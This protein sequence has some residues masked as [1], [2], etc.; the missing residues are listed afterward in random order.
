MSTTPT[1]RNCL[2]CAVPLT[3]AGSHCFC[4]LP[5]AALTTLQTIGSHQ[6]LAAGAVLLHEGFSATHVYVICAGTIKLSACS[7]DGKLLLLRIAGPGDV[8]GLSATLNGA[9]YEATAKALEPSEVKAIRRA[10]FLNFIESSR[11]AS[12]NATMAI[13]WK[14]DGLLHSTRRL[15]LST[16][17]SGKLASTLLDWARLHN[18]SGDGPISFQMPLTHEELGSMAGLSRETVTRILS[19]FRKEGLLHL[20]G[21]TMTLLRPHTLESS[22]C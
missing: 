22:Y 7:L 15:A 16:T 20:E 21:K 6:R 19:R 11:D 13:A 4:N 5:A 2:A 9:P 12:H 14:Y 8:L 17:A 3:Q 18:P 10:E 1:T